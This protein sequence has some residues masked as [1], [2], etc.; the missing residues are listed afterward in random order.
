MIILFG[1]RFLPLSFTLDKIVAAAAEV[2]G[3]FLL[4]D[5]RDDPVA[6]A[7]AARSLEENKNRNRYSLS[8]T[9]FNCSNLIII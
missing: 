4:Q 5:D 8:Y 9:L 1:L 3:V 7:A 6:G 2:G